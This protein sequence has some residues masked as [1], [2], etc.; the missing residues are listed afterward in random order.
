M[1]KEVSLNYTN[2]QLTIS[3]ESVNIGFSMEI[4]QSVSNTNNQQKQTIRNQASDNIVAQQ[5]Q[6][7]SVSNID[8]T[9]QENKENK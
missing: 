6:N 7:T 4:I 8:T 9:R 3:N 2:S 1:N 5:I